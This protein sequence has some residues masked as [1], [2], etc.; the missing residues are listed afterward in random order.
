MALYATLEDVRH[1]KLIG[2]ARVVLI[3]IHLKVHRDFVLSIPALVHHVSSVMMLLLVF[4]LT[5]IT[6]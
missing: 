3:I 1:L 2:I 5:A 6:L 4:M